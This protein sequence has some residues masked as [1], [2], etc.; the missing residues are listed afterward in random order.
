[1]VIEPELYLQ[2]TMDGGMEV[3]PAAYHGDMCEG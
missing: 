3:D 1:M 2:S